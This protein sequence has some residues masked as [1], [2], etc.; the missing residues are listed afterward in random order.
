MF[1]EAYSTEFASY[2][3]SKRPTG[4]YVDFRILWSEPKI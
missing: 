3:N 1:V 4:R 2:E